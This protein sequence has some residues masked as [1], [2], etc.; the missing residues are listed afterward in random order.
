MKDINDFLDKIQSEQWKTNLSVLY[1]QIIKD[2]LN[3]DGS[4]D[5]AK[6]QS[7]QLQGFDAIIKVY[8]TAYHNWVNDGDLLQ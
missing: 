2:S 6:L 7:A 5:I 8:I 4:V 1:T 3:E